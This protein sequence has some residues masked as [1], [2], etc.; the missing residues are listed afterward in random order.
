MPHLRFRGVKADL[1]Q[2]LSEDLHHELAAL[3][4]TSSDNFTFEYLQT[5]SF[6]RGERGGGYPFI[7][8]L[9]FERG[10]EVRQAVASRLTERVHELNGAG[11]VAVVFRPIDPND[12]FENGKHF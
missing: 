7:E 12:Y 4:S 11:D 8:V 9:W 10:S 3:I 2:K 6:C 1:V 5:E